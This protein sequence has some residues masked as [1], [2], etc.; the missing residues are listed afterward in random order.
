M[1][2]FAMVLPLRDGWLFIA[3]RAPVAGDGQIESGAG[4][5]AGGVSSLKDSRMKQELPSFIN[6]KVGG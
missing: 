2:F 4:Q 1:Y 6:A 5:R 3:I